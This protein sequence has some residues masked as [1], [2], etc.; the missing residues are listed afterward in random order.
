MITLQNVQK[1]D[2][3]LILPRATECLIFGDIKTIVGTFFCANGTF[4]V[5][6]VCQNDM[7][8][9]MM[10]IEREITTCDH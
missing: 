4:V 3:I 9:F 5:F 2:Q 10:D 1:G 8:H 6:R 7:I